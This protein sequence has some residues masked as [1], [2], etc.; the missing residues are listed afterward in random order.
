MEKAQLYTSDGMAM[1]SNGTCPTRDNDKKL[2]NL[3]LNIRLS[4][5]SHTLYIK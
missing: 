2:F 1:N 4:F 3:L 5:L